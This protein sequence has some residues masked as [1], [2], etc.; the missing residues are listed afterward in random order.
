MTNLVGA[1]ELVPVIDNSRV[2][3]ERGE[4]T[5]GV[6]SVVGILVPADNPRER[7]VSDVGI[8]CIV[9]VRLPLRTADSSA[10]RRVSISVAK[11]QRS[12]T[13]TGDATTA[14]MTPRTPVVR[15]LANPAP[16]SKASL[17]NP[18]LTHRWRSRVD[19]ERAACAVPK[20][21]ARSRMPTVR[22]S[23][24]IDDPDGMLRSQRKNERGAP[25]SAIPAHILTSPTPMTVA[26]S[27]R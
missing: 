17:N 7:E 14:E 1:A 13:T 11:A 20:P 26:E 27:R 5:F 15:A 22:I 18:A 25:P 4:R 24:T 16:T 2:R 21:S 8:C 10:A 23:R 3:C 12:A 19:P 9:H 6:V